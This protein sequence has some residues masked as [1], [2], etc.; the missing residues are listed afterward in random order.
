MCCVRDMSCVRLC[1]NITLPGLQH[2]LSASALPL[3]AEILRGCILIILHA[4]V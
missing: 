2:A 4:P 1:A 3:P